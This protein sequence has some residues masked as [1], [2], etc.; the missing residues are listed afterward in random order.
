MIFKTTEKV[1]LVNFIISVLIK[2]LCVYN[3][4]RGASINSRDKDNET[5]LLMAVRKNNLETVKL[6]LEHSA[7]LTVKDANDKTCLFIAA[8]ENSIEA[9]EVAF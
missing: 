9:F 2:Y 3:P 8:E 7:D 4:F 5:P 1:D 6:L